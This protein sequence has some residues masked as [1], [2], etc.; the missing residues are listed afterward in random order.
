MDYK[1]A[2]SICF[3]EVPRNVADLQAFLGLEKCYEKFVPDCKTYMNM[4]YHL[5]GGGV[6]GGH[7]RKFLSNRRF[8]STMS[9]FCVGA[10]IILS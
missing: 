4:S 10:D 9:V 8:L 7:P 2:K 3:S 1:K 5:E 6:G